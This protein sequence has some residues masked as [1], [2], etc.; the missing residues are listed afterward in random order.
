MSRLALMAA[1]T[2]LLAA[3]GCAPRAEPRVNLA[4]GVGERV[5]FQDDL[6]A[7]RNWPA[8]VGQI[9]RTSYA[10]DGYLVENI[11]ASAPCLLGPV[12]PESFPAGV[13]IEV[14]AR[15][16]KGTREG[17]FGLMFAGRGGPDNRTF[18]TL[19]L[20][21]NGT[22]R[23]ATWEGKW[24]Y[25]VPPT[26]SRSVRSEYGAL[27]T[28][29]VEVRGRSIVAYVNGRPVATAELA[30]EGSGTLGFYVDQRG[31]EVAFSRLRVV[32]LPAMR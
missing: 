23:V 13:R 11:A 9:C 29:A 22:Y 3:A 30:A 20:T 25:P 26:A 6:R 10:D 14:S 27:N 21:A 17:A 2:A 15:L 32:D 31:M 24:S 12:R 28:L 19:G 8:A 5:I 18:A 7:P 4:G 16:R 1:L